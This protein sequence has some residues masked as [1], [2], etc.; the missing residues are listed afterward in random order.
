GS[1]VPADYQSFFDVPDRTQT[2]LVGFAPAASGNQ[3]RRLRD[4]LDVD[5]GGAREARVDRSACRCSL[6][7]L[8]RSTLFR[9]WKNATSR[10]SRGANLYHVRH[11]HTWGREFL[12]QL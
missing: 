9:D 6:T 8:D 4:D 11:A 1:G 2:R 12:S 3:R 5:C 10:H 7:W